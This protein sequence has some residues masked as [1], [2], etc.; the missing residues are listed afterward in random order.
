ML[1]HRKFHIERELLGPEYMDISGDVNPIETPSMKAV[2][3]NLK[4]RQRSRSPPQPTSKRSNLD[5]YMENVASDESFEGSLENFISFVIGNDQS[6][7]SN[8]DY[9]V[10]LPFLTKKELFQLLDACH[11]SYK[12]SETKSKLEKTL[13]DKLKEKHAIHESFEKD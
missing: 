13:R 9:S 6:K 7:W 12:Q 5:R 2:L 8:L 1:I 3:K 11:E 4:K 10:D